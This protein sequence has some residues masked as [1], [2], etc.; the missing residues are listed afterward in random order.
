[1]RTWSLRG[2][3]VKPLIS[4]MV[5]I[6][7]VA[8]LGAATNDK[9]AGSPPLTVPKATC[10]PNDHP[11]TGLQGQ[12]PAA[13]RAS[14]FKGFNCNLE[15]VGQ[16]QG[17]GANWQTTEFIERTS[18]NPKNLR[19]SRDGVTLAEPPRPAALRRAGDRCHRRHEPGHDGVPDHHVDAR[20]V[21]VAQ[22]QRAAPAARG[23]QRPQRRRRS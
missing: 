5:A 20:P 14:G 3:L 12:V 11:E 16:I 10:G 4:V 23:G 22:G 15:L 18:K 8:L 19:L 7:C 17:D 1:M 13:L 6:F 2:L 21:G 9:S